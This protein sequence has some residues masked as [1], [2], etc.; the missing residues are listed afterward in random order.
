MIGTISL[1]TATSQ[2]DQQMQLVLG[3][4]KIAKKFYTSPDFWLCLGCTYR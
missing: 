2:G 4:N 1:S 3:S